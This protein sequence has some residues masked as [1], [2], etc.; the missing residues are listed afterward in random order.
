MKNTIE[1]I[2]FKM[3]DGRKINVSEYGG[4][5]IQYGVTRKEMLSPMFLEELWKVLLYWQMVDT[6]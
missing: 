2:T 1:K 4:S 5:W 3:N 6:E